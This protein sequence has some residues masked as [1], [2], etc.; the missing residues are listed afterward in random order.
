MTT[1]VAPA[2]RRHAARREFWRLGSVHVD[3]F[4]PDVKLLPSGKWNAFSY[5]N[6]WSPSQQPASGTGWA[7]TR[8]AISSVPTETTAS[9]S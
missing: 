4:V 7:R 9:R 3:A 1:W 2:P 6:F 5:D 8:G